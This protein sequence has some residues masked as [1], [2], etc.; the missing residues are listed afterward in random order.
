M[1]SCP[2]V[3]IAL[4]GWVTLAMAC[5][6]AGT[7]AASVAP[8][9]PPRADLEVAEMRGDVSLVAADGAA[10][11]AEFGG[12]VGVGESV[13]TGQDGTVRL[14]TAEGAMVR[15][16]RATTARVVQAGDGGVELELERG[17]VRA[18]VR[19]GNGAVKVRAGERVVR[20]EDGE[21]GVVREGN[22]VTV[23][24]SE[25][26]ATVEG[27]GGARRVAAG[28]R[29]GWRGEATWEAPIG[30][31]PLLEV[32]WP[33]APVARPRC[34]LVGK[35][36]PGASVRVVS[37]AEVAPA[38]ADAGGAFSLEVPLP[39]GETTLVLE[40]TDA[41]GRVRT[42]TGRVI[43]DTTAPTLR[44]EVAPIRR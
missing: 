13:R 37:I 27:P 1:K 11:A 40:V 44:L 36:E 41:F 12:T 24:A 6:P 26:S 4:C 34:T 2:V 35:V 3:V 5:A 32:A 33:T 31:A 10:R 15:I 21:I 19:P 25:G 18:R 20:T 42:A 16:G 7:E 29:V 14:A 43:R 39:E 8:T 22:A 30:D 23:E 38:V 17:Q 9:P 28:K